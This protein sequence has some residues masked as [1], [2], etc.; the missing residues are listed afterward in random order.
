MQKME[1][2][3]SNRDKRP[4]IQRKPVV[5]STTRWI[6]VTPTNGDEITGPA[7]STLVTRSTKEDKSI[8]N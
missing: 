7:K 8:M 1:S 4:R 6:T 2:R 5:Y 3:N